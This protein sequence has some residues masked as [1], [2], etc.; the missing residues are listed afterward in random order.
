M[1]WYWWGYCV[2]L[3]YDGVGVDTSLLGHINVPHLYRV[4]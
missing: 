3:F 4:S 1:Y 2:I